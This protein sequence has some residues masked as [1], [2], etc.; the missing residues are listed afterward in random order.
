[1]G[2]DVSLDLIDSGRIHA[3]DWRSREVIRD[4]AVTLPST[5]DECLKNAVDLSHNLNMQLSEQ[6]ASAASAFGRAQ[7]I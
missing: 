1:M 7:W 6:T 4:A 5:G 2:S 3:D